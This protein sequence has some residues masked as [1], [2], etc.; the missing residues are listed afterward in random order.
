MALISQLNNEPV[1]HELQILAHKLR[2]HSN[3]ATR[4]RLQ[5]ELLLY[6]KRL[7]YELIYFLLCQLVHQHLIKRHR[8]ISVHTLIATD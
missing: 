7:A 2:V 6:L 4:E 1:R 3:K 8:E 5:N